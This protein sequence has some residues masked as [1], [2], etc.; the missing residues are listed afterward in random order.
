MHDIHRLLLS[1]EVRDLTDEV[2]RLFEDLDRTLGASR[3]TPVGSLHAGRSTS[4]RRW[5][6]WRWWSI[7]PASPLR[8]SA[9]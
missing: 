7:C 5:T 6:R 9:C 2:S 3:R 4:R 8:A 1:S